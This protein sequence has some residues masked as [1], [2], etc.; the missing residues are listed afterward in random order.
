MVINFVISFLSIPIRHD[1]FKVNEAIILVI[2]PRVIK[3]VPK[4]L[5]IFDEKRMKKYSSICQA[6]KK[7]RVVKKARNIKV[8]MLTK[9]IDILRN[10][11]F[12]LLFFPNA[13]DKV[14]TLR[15]KKR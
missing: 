5:R 6:F 10:V 14:N 8:D 2:D 11:L 12:A 1:F 3:T 9:R 15:K 4:I 13:F 7:A